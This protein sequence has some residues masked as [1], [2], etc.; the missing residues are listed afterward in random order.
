MRV[1]IDQDGVVTSAG[2]DLPDPSIKFPN[3]WPA[4]EFVGLKVV[5]GLS[6]VRL[7]LSGSQV[8]AREDVQKP[9][10]LIRET[11]EQIANQVIEDYVANNPV[12]QGERGTVGE[13]GPKGDKGDT[14]A[15]GP[16]GDTGD[17]GLKG[18]QGLPGAKG[19]MGAQG[20]TGVQGAQGPAGPSGVA[21]DPGPQGPAGPIGLT[22]TKGDTG[23]Q[24]AKGDTGLSGASITTLRTSYPQT[25]TLLLGIP[26][27]ITFTWN[28]A[29]SNASYQHD[30]AVA[31]AL[32]GKVNMVVKSK[33]AASLTVTLTATLGVAGGLIAVA[34]A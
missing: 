4:E 34:W 23:A 2:D 16:K 30:V 7:L 31:P 10:G 17:R 5:T 29:F 15:Q 8:V 22:G 14:G 1:V 11:I 26:Q 28:S 12:V 32:L 25:V 3:N 21:G 33:T 9:S 6:G 27:D 19:D 24:G 18:D 13:T 20:L